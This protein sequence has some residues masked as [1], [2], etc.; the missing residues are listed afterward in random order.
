[1]G[2]MPLSIVENSQEIQHDCIYRRDSPFRRK[3]VAANNRAF[4]PALTAVPTIL[5]Q[6]VILWTWRS[7]ERLGPKSKN[8]R[9]RWAT[10]VLCLVELS[11]IEPL[12]STLPVLRS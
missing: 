8:P 6:S 10:E 5:P 11:G 12:T 4:T 1:M 7:R 3:R 2:A 9:S